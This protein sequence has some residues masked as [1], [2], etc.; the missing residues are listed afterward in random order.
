MT[1]LEVFVAAM[2]LFGLV[3]GSLMNV[4]I[5]RLPR[6]MEAAGIRIASNSWSW[7]RRAGPPGSLW[8]TRR[9]PVRR[10]DTK[11]RCWRMFRS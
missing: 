4:V 3:A 7:R 1:N 6:M 5:S 8:D 9:H 10:V 2:T 11:S